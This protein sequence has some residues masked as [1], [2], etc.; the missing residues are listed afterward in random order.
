MILSNKKLLQVQQ[1]V[2]LGTA[3]TLNID[4]IQLRQEDSLNKLFNEAQCKQMTYRKNQRKIFSLN[5]TT[6]NTGSSFLVY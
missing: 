5:Q 1:T 6:T 2:Q 3:K 4:P